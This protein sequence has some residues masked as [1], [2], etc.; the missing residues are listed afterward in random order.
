MHMCADIVASVPFFEDAEE[1]FTTSVVTCLRHQVSLKGD[2]LVREGEVSREM[3][4]VK[5]GAAQVGDTVGNALAFGELCRAWHGLAMWFG[6]R[7]LAGAAGGA[8]RHSCHSP[9]VWQLL[10]GDRAAEEH[11]AQCDSAR[12][13][14]DPGPLRAHQ[15]AAPLGLNNTGSAIGHK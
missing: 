15:G 3:Y 11:A 2:I 4:F 7:A 13:V 8:E 10:W 6:E 9:Q 14:S 5:S 12:P 1:G